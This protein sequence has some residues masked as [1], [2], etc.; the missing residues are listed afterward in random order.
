M[1]IP[2]ASQP[3]DIALLKTFLVVV[4]TGSFVDASERL[5][6]TPSA[7]SG[8]IKRLEATARAT[9]F[10][11]TT[12]S[13]ELTSQGEILYTYARNIIELEREARARLHHTPTKQ[14]LRVGASEDFAGTWLPALLQKF[15]HWHPGVT[16]E[17]K[18]GITTNLL[19]DKNNGELDIVFGK[20]CQR[21]NDV[22][23]LLWEE[24]LVWA[25]GAS[26]D[27]NRG[28][29]LRLALFPQP[30]VYRESAINALS[31]SAMPWSLAFESTSMAGCI[32]AAI[33]GF[34]VT[35]LAKS[36]IRQGLIC[37]DEK[38]GLPSL[39]NVGFYAF[40]RENLPD[41]NSLISLVKELG[42]WRKF[43]TAPDGVTAHL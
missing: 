33:S 35:P 39:P 41:A 23:I 18:V 4:E 5:A 25:Y 34:A 9:L 21:V 8:H 26:A 32:S 16:I 1:D 28:D 2:S 14:R 43:S 27:F 15:S 6:L 19:K 11:R 30:C 3:F 40:F 12:R 37:L 22:G 7:V 24:P 31:Q 38:Q 10:N 17:L 29:A 42:Q 13:I 36:Q 20:L